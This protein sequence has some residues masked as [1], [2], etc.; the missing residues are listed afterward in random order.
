MVQLRRWHAGAGALLLVG[1]AV[2]WWTVGGDEAAPDPVRVSC[3]GPGLAGAEE[4]EADG[5]FIRSAP[6]ALRTEPVPDPAAEPTEALDH[7]PPGGTEDAGYRLDEETATVHH[8]DG[9]GTRSR[10]RTRVG[11]E[12]PAPGASV[13]DFPGGGELIMVQGRQRGSGEL[14]TAALD[15]DGRV[16][17][18]CLVAEGPSGPVD[19]LPTPSP[20]GSTLLVPTAGERDER[21]VEAHAVDGGGHLWSA[22]GS[23]HAVDDERAYVA[24]DGGITAYDLRT[25]EKSW[26]RGPETDFDDTP[27]SRGVPEDHGGTWDLVP[28]G[29]EVYAYRHGSRRALALRTHD[30]R[31]TWDLVPG[32]DETARM[33]VTRLDPDGSVL[34]D[35]GND[36]A[37]RHPGKHHWTWVHRGTQRMR[38]GE[39]LRRSD[40][41]ALITLHGSGSGSDADRPVVAAH[42]ERGERLLALPLKARSAAAAADTVLYVLDRDGRTV[43]GYDL[44]TAEELWTVSVPVDGDAEPRGVRAHDDGFRVLF[45]RTSLGFSAG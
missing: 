33:T 39:V 44:E 4:R 29:R 14:L 1:G 31:I 43:T 8:A 32:D 12:P 20:D 41:P 23:S 2:A 18:S 7:V 37:V 13:T 5:P 16:L 30:G 27:R 35:F 25:G 40:G 17:L 9:S 45:G 26:E 19:E 24:G 22:R 11:D 21:W 38:V 28:V 36:H 42:T 6:R 15:R 3:S 34:L 10:W